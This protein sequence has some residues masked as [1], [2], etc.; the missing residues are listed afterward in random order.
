M[1][2]RTAEELMEHSKTLLLWDATQILR[3]HNFEPVTIRGM[4][5][6]YFLIDMVNQEM[7]CMID[8][9][10]R[11]NTTTLLQWMGY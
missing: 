6:N 3:E 4:T 7:I 11:V 9:D 10:R 5:G 1:I 8:D 2:A